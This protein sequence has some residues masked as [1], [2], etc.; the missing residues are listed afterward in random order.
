MDLID[1]KAIVNST[2]S[3]YEM[4]KLK[5]LPTPA[6]SHYLFNIRDVSKVIQGISMIKPTSLASPDN[7][8]KL[9]VHEFERVFED[10]LVSEED[11]QFVKE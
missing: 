7:L 3:L 5:F 1:G 8:V 4:A 11:K 2:L 6:K 9:W 10:R